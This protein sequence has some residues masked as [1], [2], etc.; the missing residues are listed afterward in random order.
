MKA[1]LI[2][3]LVLGLC[4]PTGTV[5]DSPEVT[6]YRP[7][8]TIHD[9][10]FEKTDH[11]LH[12][13]RLHGREPGNTV[14]IIGG[15]HGNEPGAY[16]AADKYVD[17]TL[18]TGNL[19]I[20]PRANLGS[21]LSDQ[22]GSKGDYNRKFD[23]KL[24]TDNYDDRI[25]AIL[26]GL[27]EDADLLLNLHDGSGFYRDT[28]ID[29]QR[30]PY[31]YGQSVI[32]DCETFNLGTTGVVP[33]G[34]IARRVVNRVNSAIDNPDYHFRFANHNS[35]DPNTRYP[36]MRKTATYFALTRH[37]IPA[38]G[39][40]TSKAL[41]TEEMKVEHQVLV[42]NSFMEEFGIVAD[43]PNMN[44]AEPRLDYLVIDINGTRQMVVRNGDTLT[45][46]Q[47]DRV[48][49]DHIVGNYERHMYADF[50]GVAGFNDNGKDVV[51]TRPL[52]VRVRKDA[53]S[54]GSI[55]IVPDAARQALPADQRY[56]AAF[57]AEGF[58][59]EV[60]GSRTVVSAGGSLPVIAGDQLRVVEYLSPQGNK[61]VNVN[62][63]GFVGNTRDNR[64]EDRGYLI[65]TGRDLLRNWSVKGDG[66]QYNIAAKR[67]DQIL[68]EMT[69]E[70]RQ[71]ELRYLVLSRAGGQLEVVLA[72]KPLLMSA[73]ER[74]SILDVA[75]NAPDGT[76]PSYHLKFASGVSL[77]CAADTEL[78][79]DAIPD[80]RPLA[81]VVT[82]GRTVLG[83]F[84]FE[85]RQ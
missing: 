80:K 27:I 3:G 32:A 81:L 30:N 58:L 9:V 63:H 8:T 47:G 75:S 37:G 74:F 24:R 64:G 5:G 51:V 39:I 36:E 6:G 41:P 83:T 84:A 72:G 48:R 56:E 50:E 62:F 10:Y 11:E 55:R 60:N 4:L 25:I 52:N 19:I 71:P 70:L 16:L 57:S 18:R 7:G 1:S 33:L 42:I 15:I 31:R 20:V 14:L 82:R 66:S 54:C 23:T 85:Y 35:V 22:R 67:G 34:E 26:K 73:G 29:Q 44:L 76:R 77:D 12:V 78:T 17:L 38:F 28:W 13:Y 43:M 45:V 40:E 65:D 21:I 59:V 61:G 49:V 69:V 53:A 46:Q 68:A 2:C 79:I